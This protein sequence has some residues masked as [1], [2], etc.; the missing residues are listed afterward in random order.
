MGSLQKDQ[1]PNGDPLTSHMGQWAGAGWA[2]EA[3]PRLSPVGGDELV[4]GQQQTHH[5]AH[6]TFNSSN[7]ITSSDKSY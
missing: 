6:I 3:R 5:L 1:H 4:L 2:G 7:D